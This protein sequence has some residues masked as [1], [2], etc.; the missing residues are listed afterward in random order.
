MRF[1]GL[2]RF[3]FN[4]CWYIFILLSETVKRFALLL[5]FFFV[6]SDDRNAMKCSR[7]NR[8]SIV[9]NV[10]LIFMFTVG[11]FVVLVRVHLI[12]HVLCDWRWHWVML[13]DAL[14]FV[15]LN[16]FSLSVFRIISRFVLCWF[17]LTQMWQFTGEKP[18]YGQLFACARFFRSFSSSHWVF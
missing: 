10:V 12:P 5:F 13:H 14:V 18:F 16:I 7:G 4:F 8:K 2:V 3:G 17:V 9:L 11:Y 1:Y 15:F 6:V